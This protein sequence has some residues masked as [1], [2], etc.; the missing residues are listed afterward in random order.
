MKIPS[1]YHSI[2]CRLKAHS[3]ILIEDDKELA[4]RQ[5]NKGWQ[6]SVKTVITCNNNDRNFSFTCEL[7]DSSSTVLLTTLLWSTSLLWLC[8]HNKTTKLVPIWDP[9]YRSVLKYSSQIYYIH[10]KQILQRTKNGWICTTRAF[11]TWKQP[12]NQLGGKQ[13]L[14]A[15]IFTARNINHR[16][17]HRRNAKIKEIF[18]HT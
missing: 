12:L 5:I 4:F 14:V 3:C 1:F 8:I 18:R 2:A 17:Y 16:L 9:Y 10:I 13:W 6:D 15:S 11:W 7:V